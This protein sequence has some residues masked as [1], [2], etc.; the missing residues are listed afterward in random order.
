[1]GHA[2]AVKE[3]GMV[4]ANVFLA[5]YE[6]PPTLDRRLAPASQTPSP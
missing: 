6:V 5:P 3:R 1:M 2:L 4:P